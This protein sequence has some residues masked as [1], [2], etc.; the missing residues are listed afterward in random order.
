MPIYREDPARVSAPL[1]PATREVP[2]P[3]AVAT[4]QEAPAPAPP[5]EM[6]KEEATASIDRPAVEK[7]A[8]APAE[9]QATP[10]IKKKK[11]A[12]VPIL[13]TNLPDAGA[14]SWRVNCSARF[15]G[16][17]KASESYLS[18]AGKRVSCLMRP[19]NARG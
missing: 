3:A 10:L 5:A 16:W 1:T 2:K 18:S 12:E 14:E 7:S 4:A 19:K 11:K 9:K 8:Q 15:G 17:N 6:E 13:K